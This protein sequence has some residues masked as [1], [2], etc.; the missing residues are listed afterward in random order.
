MKR[1]FVKKVS[2]L[3]SVIIDIF[4]KTQKSFLK[5]TW[6]PWSIFENTFIAAIFNALVKQLRLLIGWDDIANIGNDSSFWLQL[7]NLLNRSVLPIVQQIAQKAVK[8]TVNSIAITVSYDMTN[9]A[10]SEWAML[11]SASQITKVNDTTKDAVRKAISEWI[12]SGENGGIQQLRKLL[13][14]LKDGNGQPLFDE[15][16]AKR[17]AQSELTSIYAGAKAKALEANGYRRAIF[18]PRAHTNCRCYIQPATAPDGTKVI[19]WYTARDE[20]V[21][22]RE[23]E[24][25]FGTVKGC[26]ELHRTIVS[27]G[28]AGQKFESNQW[29]PEEVQQ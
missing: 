28:Y 12:A 29:N 1:K 17:I 2:R 18:I 10:A 6:R 20:M 7:D 9:M 11:Y 24:T 15:A 19:V 8:D 5:S 22:T 27:E 21:C 16:R 13:G 26:K 3:P 4:R 14:E 25:P 23:I